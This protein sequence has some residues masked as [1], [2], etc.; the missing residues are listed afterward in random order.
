MKAWQNISLQV[1]GTLFNLGN[2]AYQAAQGHTFGGGNTVNYIGFGLIA[3]QAVAGVIAHWQNPDG[4][5][6]A[7]P[8]IKP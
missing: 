4:T 6:A 5:P 2:I 1:V 8:Y 7:A 3:L